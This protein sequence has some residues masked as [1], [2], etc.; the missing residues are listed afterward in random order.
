MSSALATSSLTPTA[1]GFRQKLATDSLVLSGVF[2][3]LLFGPLAFGAVDPWSTFVLEAGAVLLFALWVWKQAAQNEIKVRENPLHAPML[4]FGAVTLLQLVFGWTAYRHDTLSQALLYLAYGLLAFLASQCLRRSTQAKTLA[5]VVSAY[6]VG[7]AAF[8]LLQGLSSNGKLY[9]IRPTPHGGWFYG[10]YANHSHYAGLMEML[11]PIPLVFCLTRFAKGRIRALAAGGAA[12]MASTIFLSG[13]R[14]GMVAIVVEFIVLGLI[15]VKL[16]S[17]SKT[18]RALGYFGVMVALLLIGVGGL[19][20]S[21]RVATLSSDTQHEISGGVR[22]TIDKDGM[23]MFTKKPIL[24]WGLGAFPI[25]YPQF[26]T[27][28]TNFFIN[29]AHNDYLQL[30]VE[31]GL[32]GFG[33]MLWFLINLFRSAIRKLP[34]WPNE[35]GGAVTLACLMGCV[36]ILAHSFV[37]FNLEVQANAAWFYVLCALAASPH[38]VE[39]RDRARRARSSRLQEP[40]LEDP[41]AQAAS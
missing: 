16:K 19:E 22:W 18:A 12:L 9:W 24:G 15:L 20:L 2:A 14:G 34:D 26:R 7:L 37:D 32:V 13:S 10:P 5:V 31:M 40:D 6:G 35:I 36:G 27:F 33:I 1:T 25:A 21:Q 29:E 30:L 8:A 3:L 39:S 41:A 17:G 4:A 38:P 11:V 28:Y 23:R